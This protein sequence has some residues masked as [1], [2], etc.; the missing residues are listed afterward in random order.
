MGL[1]RWLTRRT[2]VIGSAVLGASGAVYGGIPPAFEEQDIRERLLNYDARLAGEHV[3]VYQE[4]FPGIPI[5]SIPMLDPATGIFP[6]GIS[7]RAL[8]ARERLLRDT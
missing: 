7:R 4:L 8:L 6:R 3:L 5:D 1:P 2:V